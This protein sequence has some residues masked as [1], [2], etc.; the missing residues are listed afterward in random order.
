MLNKEY[1]ELEEVS[2][3]LDAGLEWFGIRNLWC[4]FVMLY[5]SEWVH[6][7]YGNA[8]WLEKLFLCIEV[9]HQLWVERFNIMHKS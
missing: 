3:E 2:R 6:K 1:V 5:L 8:S 9:L 4:G 7:K